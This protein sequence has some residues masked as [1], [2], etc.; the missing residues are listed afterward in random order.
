MIESTATRS[1]AILLFIGVLLSASLACGSQSSPTPP[2]QDDPFP[3]TWTPTAEYEPSQYGALVMCEKVVKDQLVAPRSARFPSADQVAISQFDSD[4]PT[5]TVVGFVDSQNKMG[6]MLRTD[7][8]C[9][10]TYIGDER[11]HVEKLELTSR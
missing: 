4:V 2:S 8:L 9:E 6:A 11:W 7:Y 5:W 1:V 10:I 3:A